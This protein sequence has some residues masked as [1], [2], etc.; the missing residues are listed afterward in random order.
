MR[1]ALLFV[2]TLLG[3]SLCYGAEVYPS[4]PVRV[5]VP[6]APGAATDVTARLITKQLSER[7]GQSFIVDNRTGA[8][9]V[10]GIN[11]VATASPDGY[12]LLFAGNSLATAA[13]VQK[14]P[15]D[16]VKDFDAIGRVAFAPLVIVVRA[17]FPAGSLQEFVTYAKANPGKINFG[18]AGVGSGQ[19]L[20]TELFGLTIGGIKMEAIHYKG[21]APSL[22]DL[23][24][25]RID[26]VITTM[27]SIRGTGGAERLPRLAYA[28]EQRVPTDPD[29]PTMREAGFDLV[30]GVWWGMLAPHGL[31]S[32]IR[33]RLNAEINKIVAE[34]AF[35]KFLDTIA[36]APAP[37]TPQ[38]LQ[39]LVAKD[40]QRWTATAERAGVR[41]H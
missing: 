5:I 3:A 35:A 7:F 23:I 18:S 13:A 6:F 39:M 17:N 32:K 29:V 16:P 8:G 28:S 34:P 25:G 20:V 21:T 26:F 22:I 15:Y 31:P 30:A 2:L 27:A 36:V 33:T 38:E 19:H 9:G 10:M 11:I 24:G 1:N 12:T 4:K 14:T 41:E 40:V 37:S